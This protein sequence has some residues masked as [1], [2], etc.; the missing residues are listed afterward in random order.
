MDEW[1]DSVRIAVDVFVAC[2]IVSALLLSITLGHR[3]SNY[4]DLQAAA[5][6]DVK[7]FRTANAY[8]GTTV[9]S[10]DVINLILT[11]R[12]LPAVTIKYRNG[13]SETWSLTSEP[14]VEYTTAALGSHIG[15]SKMFTCQL[16]FD[17]SGGL[18]TYVFTEVT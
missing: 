17:S 11:G 5:A 7:E 6:A 18:K 15:V 2:I 9:Y 16:E 3:I 14:G 13:T 1:T 10:Q 12:G 4:M 8:E